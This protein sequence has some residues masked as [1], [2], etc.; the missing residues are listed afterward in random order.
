M[1]TP[2]QDGIA[3][4]QHSYVPAAGFVPTDTVAKQIAAAVLVAIYGARQIEQQL[5]FRS[6]LRNG[7]VWVIAGT[8]P[9][10]SRGGVAHIEISRRD[11][12]ILLLSH[13]R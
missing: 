5:P 10:G 13:G 9:A 2:Q 11:G 12:R 8:L 4:Q 7:D 6:T 3:Q 1:N